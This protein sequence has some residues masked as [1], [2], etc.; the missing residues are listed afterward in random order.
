M[1]RH[2]YHQTVTLGHFN[3]ALRWARDLNQVCRNSGLP[4]CRLL[5]PAAGQLNHLILETEHP[6]HAAMRQNRDAFSASA[7]VMAVYRRGIG[8]VAPGMHPWDEYEE[9]APAHIA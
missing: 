4:E 8:F 1:V 5:M 7:E 2:R 6:D 3:D 9:E